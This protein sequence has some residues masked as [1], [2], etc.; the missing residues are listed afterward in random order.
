MV[1]AQCHSFRDIF[2]PDFKAGDDFYDHFVP[3]L[4]FDQPVD[5][6]PAYWPDGRTRRFST[7]AFGFWQS[8]CFSQA[9]RLA[10]CHVDAHDTSIEK[11]KQLRP[12]YPGAIC[13]VSCGSRQGGDGAYASCGW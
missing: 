8:R 10:W 13:G 6:D 4:E 5:K 3:I 7:D 11:A 2:V 1:C 9:G 12:E